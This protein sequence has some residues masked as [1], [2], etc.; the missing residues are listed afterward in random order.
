MN[1]KLL[2][3][4]YFSI[5]ITFNFAQQFGV[6]KYFGQKTPGDKPEIFAKEIVSTKDFEHGTPVFNKD[7]TEFYISR[8]M[9]HPTRFVNYHFRM[10]NNGTWNFDT[11]DLKSR[12]FN[13]EPFL[14]KNE[15][16]VYF[17][18]L[19]PN[20]IISDST[21]KIWKLWYIEKEGE[22]WSKP[23]ILPPPFGS[24]YHECQFFEAPDG[25]FYFTSWRNGGQ[26]DLF[27][28]EVKNDNYII[29][30]TF[31]KNFNTKYDEKGV[32]VSD[33]GNCLLFHSNR[34]GGKGKNDIYISVK[35]KKGNWE[36]PVNLGDGVN[37]EAE[38]WY[39]RV[40]PDGKYF[41]FLSNRT[42]NFEVYWV[43]AKSIFS[44]I[45]SKVNK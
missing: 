17:S 23:K 19:R 32:F 25:S 8:V 26:P 7:L 30:T 13:T 16:R 36:N 40:S 15:K 1:K 6:G 44:I 29:D 42:G 35:D 9:E 39:P 28:I 12:Y 27:R 20:P 38:E 41:F 3:L 24:Q 10:D 45:K 37:S 34:P 43:D 22:A 33:D 31:G 11:L 21:K 2:V 18:S 4:L 14:S 5:F